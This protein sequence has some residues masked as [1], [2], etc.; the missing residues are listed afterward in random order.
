MAGTGAS[1]VIAGIA[2]MV[3]ARLLG[4][5]SYGLY[6]LAFVLPALFASV[7]DFGASDALTR[8]A[9]SLRAQQKY[10][11]LASMM[12]SGLFL[13]VIT[14]SAAFL[15]AFGFSSQLAAFVLDRHDM[16]Q[17]VAVASVMIVF[18]GLWELSCE[19]LV[20]LDR[21]DQSALIGILPDVVRV[22]LSPVLIVVGL[23]VVGAITGQVSGY[24]LAGLLG[25]WLLLTHRGAL[26]KMSIE[27]GSK[28]DPGRDVRTMLAYGLPIYI[29]GLLATVLDQYQNIV[30]AFFTSNAEIGNFNAAMNFTALI[31]IVATPVGITLFPAF[32][33]LDLETGKEALQE[34]FRRSVRYT[35]LTILPVAVLVATLSR[36]L[37][38]A[39]YGPAFDHA[40]TY[41][42]LYAGIF[43]LTGLGYQVIGNFLCGIGRTK[44]TLKMA[45]LQIIVFIPAAPIMAWL[46]D[47]P[48]VIVA[49]VMSAL[50]ATGFGLWL[51]TGT[52]GMT[53]DFRKSAATL[54][55][56]LVST[57]PVLLFLQNSPFLSPRFV[58]WLFFMQNSSFL[59]FPAVANVVVSVPIY[60]A[61]YL[62]LVPA[63]GA[64]EQTD[65]HTL[66][67]IF[68][69]IKILG[70]ATNSI[71]AY[72]RW[73]LKVL[74]R[75]TQLTGESR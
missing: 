51:T 40:S 32:S 27:G 75:K 15:L 53:V 74:E 43:L 69:Q 25:M 1:T 31:G 34:L 23:G 3:I 21:A 30:L 62:T 20:G 35:T 49:V 56:A 29:G 63:L 67:P 70:T 68:G 48:G 28:S 64:I 17:L 37:V 33:K 26:R 58:G 12:S 36:D 52:Y 7:I 55:A 54:T 59:F 22:V 9:A 72:E 47:V 4:P 57:L 45:V 10:A 16:G 66:A 73:L 65:F 50:V 6:S 18:Q 71:F 41:L 44:E 42:M 5:S 8:F 11:R 13:R 60:L 2:S 14:S 61:A 19:T 39:L 46:F 24:A 38:L